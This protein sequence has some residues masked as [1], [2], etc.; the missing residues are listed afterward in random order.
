[1]RKG[2][3]GHQAGKR[4]FKPQQAQRM[5]MPF[6]CKQLAAEL[7]QI[8]MYRVLAM[9]RTLDIAIVPDPITISPDQHDPNLICEEIKAKR[10]ANKGNTFPRV[11]NVVAKLQLIQIR[12]YVFLAT[13]LKN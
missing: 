11:W 12:A 1:M 8:T 9:C 2:K 5:C 7:I 3:V 13:T 4:A 10:D 6:K